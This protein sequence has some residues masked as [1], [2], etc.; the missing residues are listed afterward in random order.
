MNEVITMEK[1]PTLQPVKIKWET[2]ITIVAPGR[3]KLPA[4]RVTRGI[5][6]TGEKVTYTFCLYEHPILQTILH[7][8]QVMAISFSSLLST[9]AHMIDDLEADERPI[10]RENLEAKARALKIDYLPHV[11]DAVPHQFT[12][13]RPEPHPEPL[14]HKPMRRLL[15]PQG[16]P[17]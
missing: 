4:V 10:T 13:T 15:K 6:P 1:N 3:R 16:K 2:V 8:P 9:A 7:L 17:S 14:K 12:K 11:L 5:T